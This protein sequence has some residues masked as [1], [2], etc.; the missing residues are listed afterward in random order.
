MEIKMGII[1]AK[2]SDDLEK[3]FRN[4]VFNRFGMR[5]GN[6]NKAINEAIIDWI[7]KNKKIDEV[8]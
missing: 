4:E 1:N 6:L 8:K 2:L 5:K 3:Q 7:K